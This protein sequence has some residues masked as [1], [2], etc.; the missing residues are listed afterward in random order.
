M[1]YCFG[2]FDFL[3][4]FECN[5]NTYS[6]KWNMKF[7]YWTSNLFWSQIKSIRAT[8][9]SWDFTSWTSGNRSAPHTRQH[10]S[11]QLPFDQLVFFLFSVVVYNTS[12]CGVYNP[13]TVPSFIRRRLLRVASD[14][15]YWKAGFF[16][17]REITDI[18]IS[19][20][21]SELVGVFWRQTP[22]EECLDR[23][24]SR[25]DGVLSFGGLIEQGEWSSQFLLM[26]ESCVIEL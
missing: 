18:F 3:C 11:F 9:R 4:I 8:K 10:P 21:A 14:T 17:I 13:G 7:Q 26:K 19:R 24:W 15:H 6:M 12:A 1:K 22:V 5:L 16:Y 25:R 20:R 23:V 2:S